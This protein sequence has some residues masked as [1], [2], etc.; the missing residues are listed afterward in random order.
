M[1]EKLLILEANWT[2]EEANYISDSRSTARIYASVE[3]LLSLHEKP[4]QIIQRPL[5]K[6]R[7][8]EDI[9]QFVNLAANRNG[10]NIIILSA[11]GEKKTLKKDEKII[12]RRQISAIDGKINLSAGIQKISKELG[13]TILILDSCDIGKSLESF[14]K[15][16]GALGVIG[17]SKQVDW[18]DSVV[19]ILALLLKYQE[20]GVFLLER[21]SL[22]KPKRI[23]MEMK[24]GPYDALIKSLEVKY[25]FKE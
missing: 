6:C 20:E 23:L 14:R 25:S 1:N 2:D 8:K 13:R 11:H 17:F 3:A 19:F 4:I 9:K 18:I 16:S 10:V 22:A 5:L 7:Y 24:E 21:S 12:H 15:A